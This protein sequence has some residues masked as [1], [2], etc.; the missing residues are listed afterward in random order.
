MTESHSDKAAGSELG[1]NIGI[2][3]V[4]GQISWLLA[5]SD[6]LGVN[7]KGCGLAGYVGVGGPYKGGHADSAPLYPQRV[8]GSESSR[9][10]KEILNLGS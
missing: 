2:G 6:S 10:G 4:A 5:G 3:K 1:V 9:P 8:P 7:F